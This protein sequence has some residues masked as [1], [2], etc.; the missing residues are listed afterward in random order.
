MTDKDANT[1][2][3]L[4]LADELGITVVGVGVRHHWLGNETFPWPKN[5]LFVPDQFE[6]DGWPAA[7]ELAQRAGIYRG[8]AATRGQAAIDTRHL[9]RGVWVQSSD[10]GWVQVADEHHTIESS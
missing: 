3:L 5:S 6:Y 10:E 4:A 2:R 9:H 7:W 8:T 1:A